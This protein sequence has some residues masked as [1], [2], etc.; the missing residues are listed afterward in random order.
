MLASLISRSGFPVYLLALIYTSQERVATSFRYLRESHV[1]QPT[2]L[3]LLDS[4][5]CYLP[6]DLG[7]S[8]IR[9]LT[10][11]FSALS[12][13]RRHYSPQTLALAGATCIMDASLHFLLLSLLRCFP[14]QDRVLRIQRAAEAQN[15]KPLEFCN[16][17]SD[18]FRVLAGKADDSYTRLLRHGT[19]AP[20]KPCGNATTAL[21]RYDNV[22]PQCC[23]INT[24]RLRYD[25]HTPCESYTDATN[26]DSDVAPQC[27]DTADAAL[28]CYDINTARQHY[29]T[30]T[31]RKPSGDV[32]TP[33]CRASPPATLRHHATR[34]PSGD[35]TTPIRCAS[36]AATL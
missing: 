5:A 13:P 14:Q 19:D 32:T 25:T 7:T 4:T 12:A 31:L 27:Y 10:F 3:L 17:I 16:R 11:L 15:S 9:S 20:C 6:T 18:R 26:T 21:Q 29:D 28:Q 33:I 35:V 2:T 36:P 34:K 24:S 8:F 23:D 22:A 30:H 1:F